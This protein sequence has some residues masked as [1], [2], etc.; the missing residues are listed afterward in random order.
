M[1][2]FKFFCAKLYFL[3]KAA[4]MLSV[5]YEKR[6]GL[7]GWKPPLLMVFA[8]TSKIVRRPIPETSLLF[9]FCCFL[10][11]KKLKIKVQGK[12]QKE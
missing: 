9:P 10:L 4:K 12:N 6:G 5:T 8:L 7:G 3:S 1:L 2:L 11:G